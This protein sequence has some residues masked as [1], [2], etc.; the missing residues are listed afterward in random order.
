M[1][2]KSHM[3]SKTNNTPRSGFLCNM[4][5]VTNDSNT[6]EH[7]YFD[8]GCS[9]H[10]TRNDEYLVKVKKVKGGKFTFGDSGHGIINGLH[11]SST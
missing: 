7:W 11:A 6:N 5:L 4:A 3:Y 2:E 1:G 10:M 9:R 8:S